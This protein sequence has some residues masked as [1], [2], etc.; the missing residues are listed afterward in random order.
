MSYSRMSYTS[1]LNK[2]ITDLEKINAELTS[3][4]IFLQHKISD[5]KKTKENKIQML[6]SLEQKNKNQASLINTYEQKFSAKK[7]ND[8][9]AQTNLVES[10]AR[11]DANKIAHK[12]LLYKI[13]KL[14]NIIMHKDLENDRLLQYAATSN[15][16]LLPPVD[17]ENIINAKDIIIQQKNTEIQELS[18]HILDLEIQNKALLKETTSIADAQKNFQSGAS[19]FQRTVSE[20][21]QLFT[22]HEEAKKNVAGFLHIKIY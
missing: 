8:N 3:K 11:D 16:Q 13:A 18:K 6:V 9:Q 5:L 21:I 19:F 17:Y 10:L 20:R 15:D 14:E 4:I 1:K 12:N 7:S 2:Q 22:E